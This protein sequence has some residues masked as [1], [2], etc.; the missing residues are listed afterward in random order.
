MKSTHLSCMIFLPLFCFYVTGGITFCRGPDIARAV[1]VLRLF[2]AA[3]NSSKIK[4]NMSYTSHVNSQ[5]NHCELT[6]NSTWRSLILFSGTS[7]F[8]A[9][10]TSRS[11]SVF[12][13][14]SDDGVKLQTRQRSTNKA[15]STRKPRPGRN[16]APAA[17]CPTES[18]RSV[19]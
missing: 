17:D 1:N 18:R 5:H 7:L 13:E 4:S 19:R 16:A 8:R 14:S 10:R 3:Y 15:R 2:C 9:I 6:F 12:S 11:S